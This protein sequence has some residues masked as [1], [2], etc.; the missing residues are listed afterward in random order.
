MCAAADREELEV[1][2]STNDCATC[3][4]AQIACGLQIKSD[5]M[6]HTLGDINLLCCSAKVSLAELNLTSHLH[7]CHG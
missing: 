1:T 6:Q 2:E 7:C 4:K 5:P 3:C